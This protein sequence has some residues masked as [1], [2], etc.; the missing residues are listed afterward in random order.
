MHVIA[1]K[2]VAF[3]EALTPEFKVYAQNVLENSRILG[4]TLVQH[5]LD[6]VSAGTDSHLLLVDLRSYGITGS[7]AATTLEH[8]NITCNKNGIPFD[9]LPPMTTS[10]IRIGSPAATS[11]GFGHSEFKSVADLIAE[12]LKSLKSGKA[13]TVVP[14]VKEQVLELCSKFPIY[15]DL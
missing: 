11:R 3:G 14:A 7:D 8:A 1:A 2:A 15:R 4:K 5:G 13:E 6:L 10:G 12:V 9:P